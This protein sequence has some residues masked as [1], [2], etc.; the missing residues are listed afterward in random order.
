[1]PSNFSRP[2][3]PGV[4]YEKVIRPLIFATCPDAETAHERGMRALRALHRHAAPA[5]AVAAR[6]VVR[7]PRL[8]CSVMGLRFPNPVGLAGGF[9]KNAVA[10]R[11]FEALGFGFIEL[12]TVTRYPQPGNPR[13]RVFRFPEDEAILNRFGFNNDGAEAMAARLAACGP[14]GIPVGISLG[15]SKI[16]PLEDAAEDYLFSL[17]ALHDLG[18]YFAVN[19]SSPNTPN[20]RALQ[21]GAALDALLQALVAETHAQAAR[22]PGAASPKPIVVKVAPDLTLSALDEVL[23]VC[24]ARGVAGIVATN[25][26]LARDGLS[27]PTA[28][29]GGLSGRP[30][31]QRSRA[32]VAHIA[33]NAPDLALIGV[34]GIMTP[35]DAARMLDAGA[36]LIQIYTGFVYRGPF[37][38]RDINRYLLN[39]YLSP[40]PGGS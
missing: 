14:L 10:P 29:E 27:R 5:R 34:G 37:F 38:P 11:A 9:D 12:G 28:E 23:A 19:V 16:T 15:K 8:E 22:S 18:D 39:K 2:I 30:L 4:I 36:H 13:P 25:T 31:T 24:A 7:D 40:A 32:M 20:L 21:D 6:A 35:D 3:L 1:M 17:R 26:T 33:K